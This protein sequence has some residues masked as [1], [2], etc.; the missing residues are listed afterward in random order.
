MSDI[1]QIDLPEKDKPLRA[2]VRL[3]GTLVG[4]VL[5]DQHGQELL[6]RVEAVRKAAI[7]QR[8][9]AEEPGEELD[10]LL[11][12]LEPE[13]VMRV[14]QAFTTYLRAVNLAEKVHR[15][16]RRRRAASMPFSL[17]SGPRA[18]T[19][20][21]WQGPWTHC[22]S[23]RCSRHIPPRQRGAPSRKRNT[24]SCCAWWNGSTPS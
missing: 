13:Y 6:D 3:L 1:R 5:V 2:D 12:E 8:E 16:R 4:Q 24:T 19:D 15:I 18:W 9:H 11:S 10:R 21:A 23:S 14:I 17:T 7:R 22:G 20:P